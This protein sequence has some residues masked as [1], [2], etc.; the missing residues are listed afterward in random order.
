MA[1]TYET[2]YINLTDPNAPFRGKVISLDVSPALKGTHGSIPGSTQVFRT[3]EYLDDPPANPGLESGHYLWSNA[4]EQ[5]KGAA[6]ISG[7]EDALKTGIKAFLACLFSGV[8]APKP[9][10]LPV[11][12]CA[13]YGGVGSL[14]F[15]ECK[16][17]GLTGKRHYCCMASCRQLENGGTQRPVPGCSNPCAPPNPPG[18]WV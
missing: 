14:E 10:P 13:Q 4:P 18:I 1:D 3:L 16:C 9:T 7:L 2:L 5:V 11:S 15:C 17:T 8:C 12:G 6:V